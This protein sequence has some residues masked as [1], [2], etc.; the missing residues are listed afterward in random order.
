MNKK[1]DP[2][3]LEQTFSALKHD[4]TEVAIVDKIMHDEVFHNTL[5]LETP[6]E[7][8]GGCV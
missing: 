7:L 5:D 4:K 2:Y 6:E 8:L 1:S 3:P